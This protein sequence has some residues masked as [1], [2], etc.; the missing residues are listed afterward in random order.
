MVRLAALVVVLAVALP[1]TTSARVPF[2]GPKW[3]H[4]RVTYANRMPKADAWSV[5]YAVRQWNASGAKVRFVRVASARNADAVIEASTTIFAPGITYKG[6]NRITRKQ[7][8]LVEIRKGD[9]DRYVTA[10]L[11]THELGHVLGLDHSRGCVVMNPAFFQA[12]AFSK[13]GIP[14]GQWVCG[15]AQAADV[16]ALVRAYGGHAR[17]RG[18]DLCDETAAEKLGTAPPAPVGPPALTVTSAD[19]G[20]GGGSTATVSLA[21]SPFTPVKGETVTLGRY[22][23]PCASAPDDPEALDFVAANDDPQAPNPVVPSRGT[24]TDQLTSLYAPGSTVCYVL[25]GATISDKGF[26]NTKYGIPFARATAE[27]VVPGGSG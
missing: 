22:A 17:K 15:L 23:G 20:A 10:M 24:F 1:A 18:P 2:P 9:R 6:Y 13:K 11:I 12:C 25:T 26:Y 27:L 7:S 14:S 16:A 5:A 19:P 3:P 21:W 4:G 8:D